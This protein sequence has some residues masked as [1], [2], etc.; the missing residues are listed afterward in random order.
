MSRLQ[1]SISQWDFE[2]PVT[3]K[4][5]FDP[6]VT[7]CDHHVER[8]ASVR[9][10]KCPCCNNTNPQFKNASLFFKNTLQA[11]VEQNK[12]YEEVYFDLSE[13]EKIVRENKLDTPIGRLF[14]E[15]LQ[16]AVT[17]LN[18]KEDIAI[19]QQDSTTTVINLNAVA[20][21]A[22]TLSGRDLLRK[23]LKIEAESGKYFFGNAEI[24]TESL[25]TQING[26]SIREWLNITTAMEVALDEEQKVRQAI[27]VEA[28]SA[29]R[30]LKTEFSRARL[31]LLRGA[32]DITT[33]A[34]RIHSDAVNPILQQVVYGEE[35]RVEDTL[36]A[37]KNNAAQLSALLSD[38]G[39]VK[40]YS[41]RT[42]TGMTLLLAAAAAGD[43]DMCLMLK[44]YMAP[45]EFA[46]QL[47]EIFPEG[48]EAHESEQQRNTFNFDAILAAIR[49]ANTRALDAALNKTDNGSALCRA[50]EKF[51]RQFTEISNNEKIFNPQHLLRAFEVYNA[52]WNQC[53][54]DGSDHDYQKRDLFWRQIIGFCQR[55]MPACYAQAFSQGLYYLVKEDQD[56]S[57][58]P[59]TFKR[60]LKLRRDNFSYFPLP[61]D[62]RSGLGFDFAIYDGRAWRGG[63]FEPGASGGCIVF[64]NFC[65]AK[66][67]GFQNIMQ[68]MR[69]QPRKREQFCMVQ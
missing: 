63:A 6:V 60:D 35:N 19:E 9:L 16:N 69:E 64:K 58:C 31:F 49:A 47:T 44:N 13:F 66:T 67:A 14:I 36:E 28:Q 17:H 2:C 7:V 21:L 42:I 26:K 52:L 37:I 54:R 12:L 32:R 43:I 39:T 68:R 45:E 59:E 15:L 40:D 4:I 38:T 18:C 5:F 62:S 1:V 24:S 53:E 11:V 25:Q 41:D 55:F 48:I 50:L 3:L 57:W 51:R 20:V 8:A 61:R 10:Q 23:K 22:S 29:Y 46:T 56:A 27:D 30:Q 65:R 34:Q 33:A